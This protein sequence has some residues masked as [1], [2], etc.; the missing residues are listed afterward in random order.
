MSQINRVNSKY[1]HKIFWYFTPRC[2]IFLPFPIES[3]LTSF[4]PNHLRILKRLY[5]F[6]TINSQ[7]FITHKPRD[8][9]FVIGLKAP[10][11]ARKPCYL[12]SKSDGVVKAPAPR[13]GYKMSR[14]TNRTRATNQPM[15]LNSLLLYSAEVSDSTLE[16]G[17]C[18]TGTLVC[19]ART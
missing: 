19:T 10:A 5:F 12:E 3:T 15:S 9:N 7:L 16:I 4:H 17:L 11:A 6:S 13:C 2:A 14:T 8:L 18:R 1:S